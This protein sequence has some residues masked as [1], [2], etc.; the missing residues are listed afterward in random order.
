MFSK[1]EDPKDKKIYILTDQYK[2]PLICLPGYKNFVVLNVD[3]VLKNPNNYYF[4]DNNTNTTKQVY[5][6]TNIPCEID[7]ANRNIKILK[8]INIGDFKIALLNANNVKTFYIE[9]ANELIQI[10]PN[11][12]DTYQK[13]FNTIINA[14]PDELLEYFQSSFLLFYTIYVKNS[15]DSEIKSS[16]NK[17][18]NKILNVFTQVDLSKTYIKYNNNSTNT[19]NLTNTNNSRNTNNSTNNIILYIIVFFIVIFLIKKIFT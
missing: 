9:L 10:D 11:N 15:T 19:N 5:D 4:N 8:D 16:F 3:K 13:S 12:Q 14:T 6:I 2:Q 1:I 17:I 7:V 18:H